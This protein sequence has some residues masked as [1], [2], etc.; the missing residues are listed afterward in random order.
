[1]HF[2]SIIINMDSKTKILKKHLK[3]FKISYQV[4]KTWNPDYF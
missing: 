1:M 3:L 2:Y 4:M